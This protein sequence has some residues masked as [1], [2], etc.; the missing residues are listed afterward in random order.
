MCFLFHYTSTSAEF[1][2]TRIIAFDSLKR[3]RYLIAIDY[4]FAVCKT[5]QRDNRKQPRYQSNI[6][7]NYLSQVHNLI[8]QS[9][10]QSL[11]QSFSQ[12]VNNDFI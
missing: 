2:F 3:S 9:L 7:S 1:Y 4:K 6:H 10:I 11:S 12:S 8:W 5:H